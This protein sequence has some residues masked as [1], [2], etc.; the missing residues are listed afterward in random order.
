MILGTV[1]TVFPVKI[2]PQDKGVTN[3]AS[4]ILYPELDTSH[5]MY[6]DFTLYPQLDT[7]HAVPPTEPGLIE[8]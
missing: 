8:N 5:A 6:S 3:D 1:K 4:R 2:V 7:S